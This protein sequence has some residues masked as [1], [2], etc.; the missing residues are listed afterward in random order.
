ME[1]S[2]V[3]ASF[4]SHHALVGEV[5]AMLKTL[6]KVLFF[7]FFQIAKEAVD[8]L[9][10]YLCINNR[11]LCEIIFHCFSAQNAEISSVKKLTRSNFFL[12]TYIMLI[13]KIL[14]L[15]IIFLQVMT[16]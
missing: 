10:K 15:K 7:F 14:V 5:K 2:V 6:A 16:S 9:A 1:L 3:K 4:T 12:T 8:S 13:Q 11:Y